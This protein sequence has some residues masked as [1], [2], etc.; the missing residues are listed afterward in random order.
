MAIKLGSLV[1]DKTGK[2]GLVIGRNEWLAGG[3]WIT[4]K[5]S[6]TDDDDLNYYECNEEHVEVVGEEVV[7]RAEWLSRQK[8]SRECK[9]S[10]PCAD[11]A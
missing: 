1:R 7:S 8:H 10:D 11:Q 9:R 5:P 3:A 4:I 2:E 6:D